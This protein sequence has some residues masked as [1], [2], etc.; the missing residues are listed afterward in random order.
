M[1]AKY[2]LAVHRQEHDN[3]V[4]NKQKNV[5]LDTVVFVDILCIYFRFC[6]V[7]FVF[8][9]VFFFSP[10]ITHQFGKCSVPHR[11]HMG[12]A[13]ATKNRTA[14]AAISLKA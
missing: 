3:H 1:Q 7:Y 8:I 6:E 12:E 5:Y 4:T 10:H 9:V 2:E 14:V 13:Y 11:I